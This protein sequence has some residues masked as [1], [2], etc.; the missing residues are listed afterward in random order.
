MKVL[1]IN[2]SPKKAGC[3]F[4]AITEIEKTLKEEGIETEIFQIGNGPVRGCID[5]MKCAELGKCVFD[6]DCANSMIDKIAEADGVIIGSPVYYASS[7]GA[8]NALLDRV[9]Y[10]GSD[11]FAHKPA[12][13]I[14]SARRGGTTATFD[15]LNKYFTISQMPIVTSTYWNNIHGTDPTQ[16]VQDLEGMQVMRNLARNMAW[17]LRC[18]ELGK[19]HGVEPPVA[20]NTAR[21]DFIR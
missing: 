4:T 3:T 16:T 6:D 17:M 7:N 13:A 18:I 19:Q 1:L 8:F 9:F 15:Q 2:G 21:T 12:A 20:E 14:A 5:C 10:A 11:K